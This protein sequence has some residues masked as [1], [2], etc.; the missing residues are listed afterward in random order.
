[1]PKMKTHKGLR[2]R[3]RVTSKGKIRHKK[4]GAGHLMST[5]N[6]KRCRSLRRAG[7]LSGAVARRVRAAVGEC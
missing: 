3:V 7:F 1:M 5:K 2:K 4:A 6:G